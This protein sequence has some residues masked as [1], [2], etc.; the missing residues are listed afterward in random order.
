MKVRF[1]RFVVSL[2][3]N[4]LKSVFL[5]GAANVIH[6]IIFYNEIFKKF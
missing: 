6:I 3:K 2:L 5:V 1:L 4:I